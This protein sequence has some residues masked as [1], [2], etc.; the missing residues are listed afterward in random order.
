[1]LR[2]SSSTCQRR[3][4][5]A[6]SPPLGVSFGHR[7]GVTRLLPPA[8]SSR[9]LSVSGAAAYFSGLIHGGRFGLVQVI[10]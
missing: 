2:T 9:T 3:R 8:W 7:K 6:L 5:R 1:M 10:K 4:Y